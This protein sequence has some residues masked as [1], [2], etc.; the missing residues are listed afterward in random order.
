MNYSSSEIFYQIMMKQINSP[1][2]YR[3]TE[4]LG[5]NFY[6]L[7]FITIKYF[8]LHC[9]ALN[10]MISLHI[11]FL[12]YR[13]TLKIFCLSHNKWRV[14]FFLLYCI[15]LCSITQRYMQYVSLYYVIL[16]CITNVKVGRSDS[17]NKHLIL[18]SIGPVD[19]IMRKKV[20]PVDSAMSMIVF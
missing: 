7:H 16:Y 13:R 18:S 3:T 11:V 9:P 15:T 1:D 19:C 12:L 4:I 20:K 8:V 14:N 2:T 6:A 10:Y 5:R 17:I